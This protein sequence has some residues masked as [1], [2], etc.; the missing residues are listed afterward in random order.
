MSANPAAARGLTGGTEQEVSTQTDFSALLA[1]LSPPTPMAAALLGAQAPMDAAPM[2][3]LPGAMPMSAAT[4]EADAAS[5]APLAVL[6]GQG[7][8]AMPLIAGMEPA[9]MPRAAAP[10]LLPETMR[11]QLMP[12]PP[13]SAPEV[14]AA[15]MV[16][17]GATAPMPM[18][19][20]A[21]PP[22]PTPVIQADPAQAMAQQMAEALV[23]AA[24]DSR[25]K[26]SLRL[27]PPELG[28]I[29][30]RLAR[31]EGAL[32]AQFVASTPAARAAM[33]QAL[34]QLATQLAAQG[35]QL[36][37][38][39]VGQQGEHQRPGNAA[40]ADAAQESADALAPLEPGSDAVRR[41]VGLFEGWA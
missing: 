13:M 28:R 23:E 18:L 38:T 39:S 19:A 31:D 35:L 21:A 27:D 14:L 24:G 15:A 29:E 36:G 37:Q 5:N 22:V 8:A 34:P 33:E 17:T 32:T 11:T 3:P 2:Q 16:N 4:P 20:A 10:L 9:A 6:L 7:K 1:L 40:S 12:T 41:S 25:W 26:V 30:V